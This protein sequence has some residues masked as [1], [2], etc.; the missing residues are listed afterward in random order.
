MPKPSKVREGMCTHGQ[1][2]A[3]SQVCPHIGRAPRGYLLRAATGAPHPAST[4]TPVRATRHPTRQRGDRRQTYPSTTRSATTCKEFKFKQAEQAATRG[5]RR[6]RMENRQARRTQEGKASIPM[7]TGPLVMQATLWSQD[8][9]VHSQ[10]QLCSALC[11]PIT[12]MRAPV[13]LM[14]LHRWLPTA[15]SATATSPAPGA[16]AARR[17]LPGISP[18]TDEQCK[19]Q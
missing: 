6:Q 14:L 17:P 2:Q 3:G 7:V 12:R 11:A 9:R 10:N 8:H 19:Q 16:A 18:P 15:A 4:L 5:S 13:V 1:G